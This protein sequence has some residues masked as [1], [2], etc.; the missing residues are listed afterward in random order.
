MLRIKEKN[1]NE[2]K[3]L[4]AELGGL[5]PKSVVTKGLGHWGAGRTGHAAGRVAGARG[6]CGTRG[7]RQTG[8]HGRTAWAYCWAVG[9]ALGALSLFLNRFDSVL[10]LSH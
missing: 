7:A 3:N 2:K 8:R 10:F 5:M 9:Y 4:N 1:N 6:A